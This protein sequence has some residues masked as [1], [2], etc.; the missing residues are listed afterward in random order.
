MKLG[1]PGDDKEEGS[2]SRVRSSSPRRSDPDLPPP[3]EGSREEGEGE[4]LEVDYL[5]AA[6]GYRRN[7][8]EEILAGLKE[9]IPHDDTAGGGDG[10]VAKV[11]PVGRD[12]KVLYDERKVDERA[13]IWLQGCNEVTHGVSFLFLFP[14][15]LFRKSVVCSFRRVYIRL[16]F[17]L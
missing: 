14:F 9:L 1:L 10:L 3:L 8:H 16:R 17:G 7:A 6:T 15:S 11:P 4:T 12:Y 2:R 5:F 13:G